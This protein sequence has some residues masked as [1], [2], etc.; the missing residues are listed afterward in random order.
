M[1]RE[2]GLIRIASSTLTQDRSQAWGKTHPWWWSPRLALNSGT[3]LLPLSFTLS[4][5]PFPSPLPTIH[6]QLVGDDH[7]IVV[8]CLAVPKHWRHHYSLL[9]PMSAEFRGPCAIR[10]DSHSFTPIPRHDL[11]VFYISITSL[12]PRIPPSNLSLSPFPTQL[13]YRFPR[14]RANDRR[15]WIL[16]FDKIHILTTFAT[17]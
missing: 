8:P 9:G 12:P 3:F 15:C 17:V 16:V 1:D 10:S 14:H 6:W 13:G 4:M 7:F 11:H 2:V 5:F